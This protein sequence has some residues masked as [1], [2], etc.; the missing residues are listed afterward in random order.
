MTGPAKGSRSLT[1]EGRAA[2]PAAVHLVEARDDDEATTFGLIAELARALALPARVAILGPASASIAAEA[3]G[4]E[5]IARWCP[6][7]RESRLGARGVRRMLEAVDAEAPLAVWS[8][9][10]CAAIVAS[11]GRPM[12]W[13][14]SGPSERLSARREEALR[15]MRT[16]VFSAAHAL[17]VG[18]VAPGTDIEVIQ[19]WIGA[20]SGPFLSPAGTRERLRKEW[21]VDEATVVV[22]VVG[23]VTTWTDFRR[24]A[25]IVGIAAVRGARVRLLGHPDAARRSRTT[26]W[27]GQIERQMDRGPQAPSGPPSGPPIGDARIAQPWRIAAGLDVGLVLG[28]GVS[29]AGADAA[30]RR[31]RWFTDRSLTPQRRPSWSALWLAAAGVP[32]LVEEGAIEPELVGLGEDA[33]FRRDDPLRATRSLVR[34]CGSADLRGLAGM[35][36]GQAMRSTGVPS[37][38]RRALCDG[39]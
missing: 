20:A 11:L 32:L 10:A 28:D 5:V 14:V 36:G 24:A 21:G 29:T 37:E 31:G 26:D 38:W 13:F 17:D 8:S 34:W 12:R 25:D 16:V 6:P 15:G 4:C 27:M 35:R 18:G 33:I 19:P 3:V 1:A 23:P 7:L 22:G 39:W 9:S 30:G 2:A